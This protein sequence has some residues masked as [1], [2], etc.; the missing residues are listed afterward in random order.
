MAEPHRSG[1]RFL[2]PGRPAQRRL[3]SGNPN[4]MRRPNMQPVRRAVSVAA[5][6]AHCCHRLIDDNVAFRRSPPRQRLFFK[7]YCCYRGRSATQERSSH[8]QHPSSAMACNV[9]TI[10]HIRRDI[11]CNQTIIPRKPVCRIG[12]ESHVVWRHTTPYAAHDA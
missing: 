4:P 7:L 9:Q 5:S 1:R 2:N 6:N 12:K 10:I 8:G 3:R 11:I